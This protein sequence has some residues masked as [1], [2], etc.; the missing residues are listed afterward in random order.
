MKATLG[1]PMLL[2]TQLWAFA[3]LLSNG[4]LADAVLFG[5][6]LVW[7]VVDYASARRR[8]RE[9]GTI[10]PPG[11]LRR[12]AIAVFIGTIAW[13]V[14]GFWLHRLLIGVWRSEQAL[15]AEPWVVRALPSVPPERTRRG[16]GG[17]P[18]A[19]IEREVS[20]REKRNDGSPVSSSSDSWMSIT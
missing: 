14:F 17:L 16:H 12:D 19:R 20:H 13:I 7:A 18:A 1:H 15:S 6:F 10:Y 9:A 8:D 4:T 5:G 3:H 11:T 2:G